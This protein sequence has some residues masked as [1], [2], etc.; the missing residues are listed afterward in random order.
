MTK[1]AIPASKKIFTLDLEN[2]GGNDEYSQ[3]P[4][5]TRS[6]DMK[7]IINRLGMHQVRENI[8]QTYIVNP[9]EVSSEVDDDKNCEIKWV[10]K[11]EEYD[12][13][14]NPIPY[15]IKISEYLGEKDTEN[16]SYIY[17]SVWPTPDARNIQFDMSN[18]PGYENYRVTYKKY[19]FT[20]YGK[21]GNSRGLYEEID[22]DG[23]TY[24]FT[25]IGIL[26]FN[27][28][29]T[30]ENN[31]KTLNFELNNVIDD[32]YIP[33]IIISASPDGNAK[34]VLEAVNILTNKRR[35]QFLGTQNDVNYQLPEHP[36]KSVDSIKVLQSTG[37][38]SELDSSNYTVNTL[39]GVITFGIAP[40][41]SL[42]PGKDNII[43]EYSKNPLEGNETNTF[44]LSTNTNNNFLTST[45][46]ITKATDQTDSSKIRVILDISIN[47]GSAYANNNTLTDATLTVK[48]GNNQ[49]DLAPITSADISSILAGTFSRT[50]TLTIPNDGAID[51]RNWTATL[52][53]TIVTTTTTST[54]TGVPGS[55]GATTY[56][57]RQYYNFTTGLGL[58]IDAYAVPHL[59][60]KPDGSDSYWDVYASPRIYTFS[61]GYLA[62][63]SRD[64]SGIIDG[65][66][67]GSLSTGNLSGSGTW[68]SSGE[69]HRRINYSSGKNSVSIAVSC[70][71]NIT[72]NGTYF[73]TVTSGNYTLNLP[74]IQPP[75]Q[76]TIT[77]TSTSTSTDSGTNSYSEGI[78]KDTD[79]VINYENDATSSARLACYYSTKAT[80]VYGYDNDRRVFVT[81]G[82]NAD[83]FSGRPNDPNYSTISYF[84][85]TNY[86][87]LGENSNILGYAQKA[88]YL[89]TVK[90]GGDSLYIRKG[91]VLNN[92]LQFPSVM[93]RRN[94]QILCR[95]IEI[96][97]N[98]YIITRN[99]LEEIGFEY[100]Q[101]YTYELVTYLRSY[102]ISNYFRLGPDYKYKQMEWF[103]ESGLLHIYLDNYEF[104][105]DLNSKSYVKE[106]ASSL[107]SQ[108]TR[109]LPYQFE[110][111]VCTIPNLNANLYAP[112][113]T[114]YLPI[115]F[116]RAEYGVVKED[117]IPYGYNSTG[118]YRLSYSDHKVDN[119]LS[120]NISEIN[121]F[122]NSSTYSVGDIV[123]YNN[124]YYRCVQ[125]VIT[126]GEW[127]GEE[128]IERRNL[129][130]GD[131]LSGKTLYFDLPTTIDTCELGTHYILNS[132]N[133]SCIALNN[134]EHEDPNYTIQT[135]FVYDI[136]QIDEYE[137]GIGI[138]N[139]IDYSD[140]EVFE[141]ELTLSNT[142][143]TINSVDT[144][145][146]LFDIITSDF[147]EGNWEEINAPQTEI[148][149][150]YPIKAH[151]FTPFLDFDTTTQLKTI[152][153]ITINTTGHNGD[154][155]Y[156]GYVL[157]DGTQLLIDKIVNT[158]NDE[159]TFLR[160]GQTP[161]PK[162]LSIK[163][164]IR[165]FSNAKLFLK[166]KADYLDINETDSINGF[167]NMTFNR[168]T[169]KYVDAGKY[170]GD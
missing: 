94:V 156:L 84:P 163:N 23:K 50:E 107:G 79:V 155:Y 116:G 58:N 68:P 136:G 44:T 53:G 131:N 69:V 13:L 82:G 47:K 139:W 45:I 8:I 49:L 12:D 5:A 57:G 143:G 92:D 29:T 151:Y 41:E 64:V 119:L 72:F 38:Y 167:N 85:D 88:G 55:V 154:E 51:T 99:G 145:N 111:Y 73:G 164:K 48:A 125:P 147:E 96:E 10:G 28:S 15:Y 134:T 108:I 152:K 24:V 14:G 63:G 74:K 168:I 118:I 102:Y 112:K 101:S 39:T 11:I 61:G 32:P 169:L 157:P 114:V 42:V 166:N 46:N 162:I 9:T 115:D 132:N 100:V 21:T 89:F 91:S 59:G 170:R 120:L 76:K 81:N 60:S 66:T 67:A 71:V 86:A 43:V 142:F 148:S 150:N 97:G 33:T 25:P 122:S 159:Q 7:N 133:E 129:N 137:N 146:E 95:P 35:V 16:N 18:M 135:L 26:S 109:G 105:F 1:F 37:Q 2:L 128:R 62:A 138:G 121:E 52:S 78:K 104:V 110:A 124:K 149:V 158:A 19:T 165:K 153:Q 80:T 98:I 65:V 75:T 130:V 87:V 106:V 113:F 31:I 34:T 127:T 103:N 140:L 144:N 93:V 90:E 4:L 161:F 3:T 22:F 30:E 36:I 6:P 20:N 77:N 160:N 141:N 27:C 117:I 70:Y 40:G 83:T 126:P 17:V 56:M 54:T 123:T